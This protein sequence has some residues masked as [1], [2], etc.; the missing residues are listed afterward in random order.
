ML[1]LITFFVA[2]RARLSVDQPGGLQ[3]TM[4]RRSEGFIANMGEEII[5][6]HHYEPLPFLISW[7][8]DIF[9]LAS[10]LI[11]HLSRALSPRP[12]S[13]SFRWAAPC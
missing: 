6:Q 9:I 12:Q 3:H 4:R 5:G 10:N 1:I 11:R 2:V 8:W 7:P 13:Q